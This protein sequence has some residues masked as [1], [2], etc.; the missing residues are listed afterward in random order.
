M[1]GVRHLK[2]RIDEECASTLAAIARRQGV[3]ISDAVRGLIRAQADARP[4]APT[5]LEAAVY[6][7]LLATELAVQLI[8]SFLPR[9]DEMAVELFDAAAEQ[10]RR[11]LERVELALAEGEQ[12][13]RP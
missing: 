10:A 2:V 5:P 4:A 8:A 7:N 3:S 1:A 6:A 13:W 9:G 12:A 11:R